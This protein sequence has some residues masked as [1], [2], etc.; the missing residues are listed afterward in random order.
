MLVLFNIVYASISVPAGVLSDKLGRKWLII[1]GWLVY[2]LVYLGFAMATKM[3]QVWV[4]FAAWGV[5]IGFF[6]GVARAFAADLVPKEK[7]GTAYGLYYGVTGL[8]LLPA[9][10]IAGWLWQQVSPPAPFF[11]GA[12]LAMTAA[13][14]FLVVFKQRPAQVQKSNKLKLVY[15]EPSKFEI[16]KLLIVSRRRGK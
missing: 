9:G 16:G 14:S 3:W 10:V 6:E 1:L 7:R 15:S 2:A 13:L 8:V 11:F 4:L 12:A 5:Y